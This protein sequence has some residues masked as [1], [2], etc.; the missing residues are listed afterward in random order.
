MNIKCIR[1][2]TNEYL[3]VSNVG[4]KQTHRAAMCWSC[5]LR[6]PEIGPMIYW[7]WSL[8]FGN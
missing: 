8:L 1:F 4:F 7:E 5:L 3:W 2:M 6:M